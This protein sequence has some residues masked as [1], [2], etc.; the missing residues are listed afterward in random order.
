MSTLVIPKHHPTAGFF[1]CCSTILRHLIKSINNGIIPTDVN[2]T[3]LFHLY[4]RNTTSDIR[5][6][7][8]SIDVFIEDRSFSKFTQLTSSTSEDQ[9][10]DYSLINFKEI[11]PIINKYFAPS[12]VIKH[13]IETLTSKYSIDYEN[14][15]VIRYRGTDKV[16]ETVKPAYDEFITKALEIKEKNPSIRFL[17][18]TDETEFLS[19]C[20]INLPDCIYFK[21]LKTVSST[22]GRGV[23]N[24]C[25][26]SKDIF[27]FLGSIFIASKCKYVITT[28]GNCDIWIALFRGHANGILQYVHHKEY[29]YGVKNAD[30]TSTSIWYNNIL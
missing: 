28:S 3:D 30:F 25:D 24:S 26:V 4:K 6:N 11:N 17:I 21:E 18:L 23:H 9:F 8:F 13:I 15:C 14:T 1:S 29:I 7:F 12:L 19:K 20:L 27:Y 16:I 5:N 2:T 10:S 22:T